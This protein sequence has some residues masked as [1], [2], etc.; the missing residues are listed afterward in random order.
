MEPKITVPCKS[1]ARYC[2]IRSIPDIFDAKVLDFFQGSD[3]LSPNRAKMAKT[4]GIIPKRNPSR[5]SD[6]RLTIPEEN[7]PIGNPMETIP[8][9][10][11]LEFLGHT[12]DKK[13]TDIT[14][15]PPAP[16]PAKNL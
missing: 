7:I 14:M 13:V 6:S 3:S 5:Q 11:F 15:M 2:L 12:S 10:I 1:S 16:K 8:I 9:I 4:R